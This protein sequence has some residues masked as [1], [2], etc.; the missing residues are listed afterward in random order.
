MEGQINEGIN[1]LSGL[2]SAEIASMPHRLLMEES[3]LAH[4]IASLSPDG[5]VGRC[6]PLPRRSLMEDLV[7]AIR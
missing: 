4:P 7:G 5:I 1:C 3:W 6:I 2:E